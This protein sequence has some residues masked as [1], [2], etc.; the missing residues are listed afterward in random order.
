MNERKTIIDWKMSDFFLLNP[1]QNLQLK[2]ANY[3]L[4][5]EPLKLN[6][7]KWLFAD[8]P[9]NRKNNRIPVII[10]KLAVHHRPISPAL[11]A[12]INGEG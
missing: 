2:Q 4:I 10:M 6:S 9:L 12:D 5:E 1:F 8:W 3:K 7:A 11:F